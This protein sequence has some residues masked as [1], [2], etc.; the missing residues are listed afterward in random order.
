VTQIRAVILDVD[1][2][3]VD[4]N[5]AHARAWA[6]ALSEHGYDVDERHIRRLIGMGGDN[7]LPRVADLDKDSEPG[8]QISKRRAEIFKMQY[9][10]QVRPL[11]GVRELIERLRGDGLRLIVASSAKADELEPLL[12]IAGVGELLPERTSA[13]DAPNSKPDPDIMQ[14]ALDKLGLPADQTIMIGDTPYDLQAAH[15]AGIKVIAFRSGGWS[16]ADLAG[17]VAIYYTPADL[18]ARYGESPIARQREAGAAVEG[19]DAPA[20][21]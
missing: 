21:G 7:L 18:L 8:S 9:L 12:G 19:T 10:S 16:D 20:A 14:V 13:E 6:D 4:S 2:T 5:D 15:K 3:L 11:P 1:G 17:A